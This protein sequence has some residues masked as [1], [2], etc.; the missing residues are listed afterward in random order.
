MKQQMVLQVYQVY[1]VCP[2]SAKTAGTHGFDSKLKNKQTP[3]TT[4]K[5]K[6]ERIM[7]VDFW[8]ID[9]LQVVSSLVVFCFFPFFFF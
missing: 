7:V 8:R 9:S 5:N 3:T 1:H 2:S 6:P 4:N